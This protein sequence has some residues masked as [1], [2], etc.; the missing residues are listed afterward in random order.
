MITGDENSAGDMG[1]FCNQ[2]DR[3]CTAVGCSMIYCHHHSKGA[4]G[5]K[6]AM[7]RASGSGV[8]AR[9]PDA[10]LDV[11]ELELSD[12]V[13]NNI[14][15]GNATG[16]RLESSLREFGNIVPL[17]FWF[18]YPIHRVDREYLS[19]LPAQ[20]T[21]EAGRLKNKCCK[22]NE[23]AN[24][25]FRNA[26]TY[27]SEDGQSAFVKELAEYLTVTEKT[28]YRRVRMLPKEFSLVINRVYRRNGDEALQINASEPQ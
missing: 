8:F 27:T 9:D 4:Q 28:V 24:E 22:T 10:R 20:G 25:E 1:A 16:W 13:K 2:F 7:D 15:D 23:E 17:E 19:S 11:I 6:K 3:I 12:A 26:F 5:M 14:R 18:E 21:P